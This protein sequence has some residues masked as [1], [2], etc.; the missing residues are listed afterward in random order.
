MES[1][2]V[3]KCREQAKAFATRIEKAKTEAERR[4]IRKEFDQWAKTD[5]TFTQICRGVERL[6]K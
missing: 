4:K 5:P 2:A 6:F 1:D 3:K